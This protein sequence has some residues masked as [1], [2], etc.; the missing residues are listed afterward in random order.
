MKA[1]GRFLFLNLNVRRILTDSGGGGS[2]LSNTSLIALA[3]CVL[4]TAGIPSRISGILFIINPWVSFRIFESTSLGL[5]YVSVPELWF[6][7]LGKFKPSLTLQI[8]CSF[9][10]VPDLS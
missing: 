5:G 10:D 9:I 8:T 3:L 2:I 6:I 7:A 4:L 1:L